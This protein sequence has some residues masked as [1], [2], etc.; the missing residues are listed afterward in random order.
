MVEFLQITIHAEPKRDTNMEVIFQR[1]HG[2]IVNVTGDVTTDHRKFGMIVYD[3][4]WIAERFDINR[5]DILQSQI[6]RMLA[7][8]LYTFTFKISL[9]YEEKGET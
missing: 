6:S 2:K 4:K 3:F 8:G 1:I 9:A 7:K 5:I